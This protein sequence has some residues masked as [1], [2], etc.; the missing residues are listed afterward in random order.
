MELA[1]KAHDLEPI[2]RVGKNGFTPTTLAEIQ[3]QVFKRR[4]IKVKMLK[5]FADTVSKEDITKQ[6]STLKAQLVRITGNII[7]LAR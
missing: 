3:K 7:I 6:L 2:V 1:K 5:A 4:L